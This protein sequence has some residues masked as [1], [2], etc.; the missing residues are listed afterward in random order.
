MISFIENNQ[1]IKVKKGIMKPVLISIMFLS[2]L[3][4]KGFAQGANMLRKQNF[5]LEKSV[6][7]Q[8]YDPVAYF[9]ENMAVKGKSDISVSY[10]DVT[11][12]FSSVENKNAFLKDPTAYEPQYGG[13]CAYAMGKSGEKVEIDPSTFKIMNGRLYLFYNKYFNNTLKSWN[14]DELNLKAKADANWQK[15]FHS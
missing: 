12:C 5:N 11:Y 4:V 1:Y 6:A 13:W 3:S 10:L 2:M 9:K 7:V 8:G 15:I 14:K